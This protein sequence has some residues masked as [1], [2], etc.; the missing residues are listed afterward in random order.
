MCC[1]RTEVCNVWWCVVVC[2][3]DV[4][5]W[6]VVV[7]GGLW[8]ASGGVKAAIVKGIHS[9]NIIVIYQFYEARCIAKW[10]P[11]LPNFPH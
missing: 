10:N 8:L 6:C 9:L 4:W 5:W 3:D 7:C 11:M 1:C 2:S